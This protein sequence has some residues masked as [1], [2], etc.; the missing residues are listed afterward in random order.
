MRVVTDDK[1][2][3]DIGEAIREKNGTETQYK[4]SEMADAVRDIPSGGADFSEVE[5]KLSN[6]Y[7][8][9][10]QYFYSNIAMTEAPVEILQHTSNARDFS[11]MFLGCTAMTTVPLFNVSNGTTFYQMFRDCSSLLTAPQFDLS[12]ATTVQGMFTN[13]QA[14][15]TVAQ[16]DTSNCVTFTNMFSNTS[17][18]A[19]PQLNTSKGEAFGYMFNNCKKLTTVGG[20]DLSLATGIA[21]MF[22]SCTA[23]ENITFNGVIKIT[24]LSLSPCS[25][26]TH[27]SLMS[28][29]NALYDWVTDGSGSGTYTLTLG[30]DNLA[31]LTDAEKAIAT[32][33]GWTLA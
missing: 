21:N 23:L 29:I 26:L 20:I 9:Y 7:T 33:K 2:Y 19:V 30:T 11:N 10:K 1:H 14:L 22:S 24:G 28:A 31:K 4:P 18:T 12:S 3:H 27:D 32:Q 15:T 25:K 16:F 6:G 8:N 5:S 13:C 17:L